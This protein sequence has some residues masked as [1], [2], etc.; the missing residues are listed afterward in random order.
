MR[1]R[2]WQRS[3]ELFTHDGRTVSDAELHA[4]ILDDAQAGRAIA[5]RAIERA[6]NGGINA[7]MARQLYGPEGKDR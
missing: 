5:Q 3:G 6:V 1:R 4:A 7:E 2:R